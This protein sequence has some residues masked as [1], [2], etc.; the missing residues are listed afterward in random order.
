MRQSFPSFPIRARYQ[1]IHLVRP[2]FPLS[3]RTLCRSLRH[4]QTQ[5]AK[6]KR[7][8]LKRIA[9]AAAIIAIILIQA[10]LESSLGF[11]PNH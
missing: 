8:T 4:L 1:I 2:L 11:T 5:M 9:V 6:V 3:N 10:H 7:P